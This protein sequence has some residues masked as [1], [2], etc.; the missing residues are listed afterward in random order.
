MMYFPEE[1]EQY[2]LNAL[3]SICGRPFSQKERKAFGRSDETC[4]NICERLDPLACSNR[5]FAAREARIRELEAAL[6]GMICPT[7]ECYLDKAP[8]TCSNACHLI[9][10]PEDT[11]STALETSAKAHIESVVESAPT[12]TGWV[13]SSCDNCGK[14]FDAHYGDDRFCYE[15][16]RAVK[17]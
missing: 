12:F 17:P 13:Q 3:C 5:V 4:S 15:F 16:D 1:R 6:W 7:C 8:D 14:R 11:G 9:K 10:L 2:P